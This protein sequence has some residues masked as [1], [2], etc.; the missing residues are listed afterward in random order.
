MYNFTNNI[1]SSLVTEHA[2]VLA[3]KDII[4]VNIN[5][6]TFHDYTN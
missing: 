2:T 1:D 3:N 4:S 6:K 5:N